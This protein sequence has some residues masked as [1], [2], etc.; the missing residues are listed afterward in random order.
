MLDKFFSVTRRKMKSNR[1]I[2][3]SQRVVVTSFCPLC[4]FHE[5]ISRHGVQIF[6]KRSIEVEL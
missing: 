2:R 5:I 1:R 3:F 4:L 6:V